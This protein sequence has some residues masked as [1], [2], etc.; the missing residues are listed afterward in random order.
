M[1]AIYKKELKSYLTSMVGFVFMFFIML[2]TGIYFTAYN[3]SSAYP[4]F[5]YTLSS[6]TFIFLILIPILTMRVL[7]EEKK[8]KTDQLLLTAPV[9]IIDVVLGKYFALISIYSI[10]IIIMCFYPLIL[11]HYGTVSY[12]M[13]Y[14]AIFGFFLLGC[15]E[16][17]IGLFISSI[18]E[19]QVIA[20]V[21]TF[22]ILLICYL[23]SG[24]ESFFSESAAASF[25]SFTV[26]IIALGILLYNMTKDYLIG[27]ATVVVCEVILTFVYFWK[28]SLLEG[29][30]QKVLEIFYITNHFSNYVSGIFD[31]SGLVYFV[32]VVALFVFMTVQSI[33][34][35]RW[36]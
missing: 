23:I 5:G 32:S 8:Q 4:L 25:F 12:P 13:A 30:I 15:A 16:I 20:A 19:S 36:S 21:I 6:I 33:Q 28:S 7:A 35:R 18:T 34:K 14:T 11:S 1:L 10:P 3:I 29:A 22:V 2:I 9:K 27:T 24:I 31:L 17:A 26:L